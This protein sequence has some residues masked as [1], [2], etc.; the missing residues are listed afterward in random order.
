MKL[1]TFKGG[2]HL[3][4]AKSLTNHKPII[5]LE[6]CKTYIFPLN[7]HIG[8]PNI[9]L[10]KPGDHVFLGQKIGDT[11]A[12]VSAPIH[13]SVSG[14]VTGIGK[15]L[16][17]SGQECD[18]IFI[19]NDF[20]EELDP[21]IKKLG[22]IDSVTPEQIVRA[23]REAGIVG[24]GGA[25]FPTHIKISPPKED[26][27][28][29][30]IV[31]G[32]ECEPYLTSDHRIM[33]ERP[34][35][36]INGLLLLMKAVKVKKGVI[37]IEE[38]K[39]DAIELLRQKTESLPE[40]EVRSLQTKYPQGSEKHIIKAVTGR[41]VKSGRLPSSAGVIVVNIDTCTACARC[42]LEGMP[43]IRRIVTLSGNCFSEPA[44][45]RVK[46]GTPFSYLIEQA[47]GFCQEPVKLIMG[48]PMMGITQYSLDV[49]VVK[50]TSA[51]LAFDGNLAKHYEERNCTRCGRCIKACPMGLAPV[52]LNLY[53]MYNDLEAA[54]KANVMDCIE[55]GSCSYVCP[56]RRQ[57]VQRFRVIKQK[58]QE[59]QRKEAAK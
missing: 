53:S 32:A 49:P 25:G 39:P 5:N 17:P 4:D 55:C 14:T 35:E 27:V 11:N 48:G 18:C 45:Y 59:N 43:L 37:A 9:P 50:G 36:V 10:V 8:A 12:H 3:D 38:N 16:T 6:P 15:H 31:N 22:D 51:I 44:N 54:K 1:H 21:T 30:I 29:T 40:I 26:T 46:T 24:M 47:G 34:H 57:L 52:Q 13:S 7:Q 2:I 33:L 56:C 28:D 23:V 58:I 20:K 41:E 19:E 42:V